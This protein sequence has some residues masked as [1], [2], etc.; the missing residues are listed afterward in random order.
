[1]TAKANL[2]WWENVCLRPR[3]VIRRSDVMEELGLWLTAAG[4]TRQ[5]LHDLVWF[6]PMRD[7]AKRLGL[8]DNG[9]RKHCSVCALL[10]ADKLDP[11]ATGTIWEDVNDSL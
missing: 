8:P 9:L 10:Q 5:Q 1:M 11:I 3:A 6:G 7:V 2:N 4:L